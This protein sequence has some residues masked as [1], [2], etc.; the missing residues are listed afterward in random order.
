M[1]VHQTPHNNPK[2]RAFRSEIVRLQRKLIREK[3]EEEI[4]WQKKK[5]VME[6][7]KKAQSFLWVMFFV[8]IPTLFTLYL[9]MSFS[10]VA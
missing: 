9:G 6:M 3:K 2:Q 5:I 7:E 1:T 4:C 8:C 10:T